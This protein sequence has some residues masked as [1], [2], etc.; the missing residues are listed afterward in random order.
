MHLKLN[1]Q[2]QQ[3]WLSSS[4]GVGVVTLRL[5]L[6]AVLQTIV[7]QDRAV[8]WDVQGSGTKCM[9]VTS[10]TGMFCKLLAAVT[11]STVKL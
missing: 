6:E 7:A 3:V 2:H 9:T 10:T 1:L 5:N 11:A 8:D 4:S